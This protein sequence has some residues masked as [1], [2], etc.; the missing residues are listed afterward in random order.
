MLVMKK[1]KQSIIFALI[2]IYLTCYF[3]QLFGFPDLLM[4]VLGAIF[5]LILLLK[6]K[7]LRVDIGVCLIA[8]TMFSYCIVVFGI[9]AI[10]IMMPYIPVLIYVLSHY[11]SKE[12]KKSDKTGIELTK[13]IDCLVFG[14][15][16][17]GVL[18]SYLYFAGYRWEGTRYWMDIWEQQI[19]P[20]T[21][22]TIYYLPIFAVLFPAIIYFAKKKGRNFIV[23]VLTLFFVYASL[24]TRTRTTLLIL[25]LV[26]GVQGILFVILEKE[27]VMKYVT[28]KRIGI[29]LGGIIVLI[30]VLVVALKDTEII[31]SFVNNLGKGG[32]ILNNVRFKVQ[33]QA[34]SQIFDYPLGGNQMVLDLKLA[35]NVWLDMANAAGLIPFF[36]FTAYTLWT[37]YELVCFVIKREFDTEVK[38]MMVGI[39]VAFFLYY[40][41]EPAINSSIHFITPWMLTNGL[42]HGYIANDD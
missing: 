14:Y 28:P 30:A 35:H 20:G 15:A 29:F 6:Q 21:Q 23:V 36:A 33:Q 39:Y 12:I 10:A 25:V 17:H 40:T 26:F 24:A 27:K 7:K 5:C 11:I 42:V 34:L 16:V 2:L 22:L 32:G 13:V 8:I 1:E 38:L 18:N 31:R 3:I 37:L 9:R 19:V 4:L 41:V